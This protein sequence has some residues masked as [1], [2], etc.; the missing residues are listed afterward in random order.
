MHSKMILISLVEHNVL[1]LARR[2]V[3]CVFFCLTDL[4][5][6]KVLNVF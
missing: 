2:P 4:M 3:A 1:S 6:F 5:C